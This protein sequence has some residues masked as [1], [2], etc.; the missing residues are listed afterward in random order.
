[1]NDTW[2][3]VYNPERVSEMKEH[4]WGN[5]YPP[6][7]DWGYYISGCAFEPENIKFKGSYYQ[8]LSAIYSIMQFGNN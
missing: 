6:Y 4:Y 8:C 2:Y 3:L 5:Q 1:M 7:F